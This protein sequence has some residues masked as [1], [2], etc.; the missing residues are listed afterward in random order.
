MVKTESRPGYSCIHGDTMDT[1]ARSDLAARMLGWWPAEAALRLSY[2]AGK[3]AAIHVRLS[4]AEG[5]E[6]GGEDPANSAN[7][8]NLHGSCVVAERVSAPNVAPLRRRRDGNRANEPNF[9]PPGA[10]SRANEPNSAWPW[11]SQ[12]SGPVPSANSAG[13]ADSTRDMPAASTRVV[14]GCRRATGAG[15][16][17]FGRPGRRRGFGGWSFLLSGVHGIVDAVAGQ[18][19]SRSST[20]DMNL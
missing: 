10:E 4:R 5:G 9:G 11:P 14:A 17:E 18:V 15:D 1:R 20:M 12:P 7:E 6:N 3:M 13:S 16:R 8:A 19:A 2:L